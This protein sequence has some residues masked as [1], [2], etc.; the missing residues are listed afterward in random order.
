MI[1]LAILLAGVFSGC[2]REQVPGDSIARVGER[3]ITH[4]EFRH[5]LDRMIGDDVGMIEPEASSAMLDQ[6]LETVLLSQL[7]TSRGISVGEDEI[8]AAIQDDPGASASEKRDEL[9]REALIFQLSQ[10]VNDPSDQEIRDYHERHI[11]DFTTG[12]RAHVRQILLRD[13]N[14]AERIRREISRGRSFEE[15]ARQYS[16][17]PTAER[18]GDI[19]TISRGDLPKSVE[20]SVFALMP[21]QISQVI[22]TSGTFHIFKMMEKFPAGVLSVERT[23]PLIVSQARGEALSSLLA[24]ETSRARQSIRTVVYTNRLDF[25]YTGGFPVD[26]SE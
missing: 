20:A 9:R 23:R 19:G 18:G 26:R 12:E 4:D 17:S 10:T 6:L 11:E 14:E 25:D 2:Q 7:A 15:A 22:E 24:E 1:P 8:N 3:F 5:Y 21:G 16:L 13:R